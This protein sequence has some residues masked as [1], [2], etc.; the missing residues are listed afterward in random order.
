[1]PIDH[2][3]RTTALDWLSEQ[4]SMHG[5]VL[6]ALLLKKG[7]PWHGRNISI[8]SQQGIFRPNGFEVPLS[9]RTG[10][11]SPYDDKQTDDGL[12]RYD[13]EGTDPQLLSN[14]GLRQAMRDQIPLVYAKIVNDKTPRQ[15]LVLFPV[16]IVHDNPDDLS[17]MVNL[18]YAL[19]VGR[20]VDL[21]SLNYVSDSK[22]EQYEVGV[23]SGQE[24][25]IERRYALRTYTQRLHQA[26]FRE[27]VLSAY[28]DRCS[29]CNL[30]HRDLLDAA[31][32]IE[33]RSDLGDP[34][35]PNGLSMCKIHH[36]AFDRNVMGITPDYTVQVREDILEEEDGPMLRHG[37]Q[38]MHGQTLLLP[39]RPEHRPDQERLAV[40]YD[41]FVRAV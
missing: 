37:I 12:L 28:Q 2:I 41:R 8:I 27:H 33:D 1:M 9:I 34:V 11:R 23:N 32:I 36:A 4:V 30:R 15:Y 20:S 26:R 14:R 35:I 3:L 38:A 5:D 7:F 6:P 21:N 16:F 39:R 22:T 31:H 40:R 17:F 29:V 24:N 10:A 13:Y 19:G 25:Q 18:E